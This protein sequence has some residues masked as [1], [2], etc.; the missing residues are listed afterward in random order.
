MNSPFKILG[1]EILWTAALAGWAGALFLLS[2]FSN[3]TPEPGIE[4]PH[5][6]KVLHFS[7]F[8][9]GG[10]ILATIICLKRGLSASFKTRILLPFIIFAVFGALDEYHQ[11]FT[12][13]R[14]GNDPFDWLADILGALCGIISANCL[15]PRLLKL[16]SP[17]PLI[18]EN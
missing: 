8:L 16:S 1:N 3:V 13:G 5:I 4:L 2:S 17:P 7:Y 11:T 15:H 14:S 12:P 10:F 18:S 9:I 6:D